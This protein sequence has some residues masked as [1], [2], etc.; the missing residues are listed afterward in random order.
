MRILQDQE[1]VK[2]LKY[3]NKKTTI[4]GITFDSKLEAKRYI[5]LK[6]LEKANEIED[7][8]LQPSFELQPSFKKNG[9]TFRAIT[10]KGDF[11]Y[12]DKKTGKKIV[13][14]TKGFKTRDYILKNKLFEYKF[15]ELTIKEVK[16]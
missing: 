16:R 11:S 9:K 13:E 5:E 6:L 2:F 15:Q 4:Q 10:Y 14:D 1:E 7:L 12:I 3:H 8:Q